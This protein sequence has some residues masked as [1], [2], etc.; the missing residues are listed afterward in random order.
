MR[1][2]PRAAVLAVLVTTVP[3]TARAQ[4]APLFQ[5]LWDGYYTTIITT[6]QTTA[7][8][9]LIAI[10]PELTAAI[11]LLI[12]VIGA[13]MVLQR[14]PLAKGV[15]YIVRAIVIANLLT[16][17]L[18]SQYV[19]TPFLVTIPQRIA[20]ALGINQPGETIAQAFDRISGGVDHM[21]AAMYAAS[22]M[23]THISVFAAVSFAQLMLLGVFIAYVLASVF[24]AIVAP[25]GAVLLVFYLFDSTRHFAE[26]WIGKMVTLMM[27]QL[28]VMVLIGVIHQQFI[29][30]MSRSEK[31]VAALDLDAQLVILWHIGL[32]FCFGLIIL[33]SLPILAGALGGSQVSAVVVAPIQ[34]VSRRI[35]R[36]TGS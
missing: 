28:L 29:V 20:A 7:N 23:S 26:R 32:A 25:V 4:V 8:N 30:F 19:I 21:A 33:I 15:V 10:A 12:I 27:L 1:R 16:Q 17:S 34:N 18:Y 36:A 13:A 6:S 31:A 35:G 2:L 14:L 11:G 9:L 24:A 5:S 3:A 22:W